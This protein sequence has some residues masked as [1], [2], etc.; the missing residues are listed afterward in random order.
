MSKIQ[1][2]VPVILF[3]VVMKSFLNVLLTIDGSTLY[4]FIHCVG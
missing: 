1:L 3:K 4:I 2:D